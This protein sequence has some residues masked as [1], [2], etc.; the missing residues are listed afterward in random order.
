MPRPG[1]VLLYLPQHT[2]IVHQGTSL[3]VLLKEYILATWHYL[4][5]LVRRVS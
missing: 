5:H 3:P 1:H 2:A 4:M